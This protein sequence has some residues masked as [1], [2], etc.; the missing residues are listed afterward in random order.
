M[1]F[2][3][4]IDY[5]QENSRSAW[6]GFATVDFG[7]FSVNGWS[8]F[9]GPDGAWGRPPAKDSGKTNE[10]GRKIYYDIIRFPNESTEEGQYRNEFL[11]E[12]RKEIGSAYKA[13]MKR[14]GAASAP[15]PPQVDDDDIPW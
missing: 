12:I 8:I 14:R 2:K 11:Y 6:R 7:A 1:K 9:D 15:P 3:V 5:I 13:E 4:K 10:E